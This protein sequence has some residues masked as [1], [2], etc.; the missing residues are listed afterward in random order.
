M[1]LLIVDWL[2]LYDVIIETIV[3]TGDGGD[4]H[5]TT[6]LHSMTQPVGYAENGM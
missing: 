6:L 2:P 4:Q 3:M 5:A 1:I